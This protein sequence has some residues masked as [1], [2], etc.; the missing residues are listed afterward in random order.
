[1]MSMRRSLH[2]ASIAAL[3]ALFA[4]PA[5]AQRTTGGISG[6]VKDSTGALLP[7]VSRKDAHSVRVT[8]K[9]APEAARFL[10][11]VTNYQA[12]LEP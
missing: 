4:T 8:V 12:S 11:F 9:D 5:L 3:V 10:S 7:G 1:M 2:F 6:T